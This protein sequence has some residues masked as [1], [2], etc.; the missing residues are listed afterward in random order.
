[1]RC[2][3]RDDAKYAQYIAHRDAYFS[4][5]LLHNDINLVSISL[6]V[7]EPNDQNAIPLWNA[8]G[9]PI[10]QAMLRE[11]GFAKHMNNR[12]TQ[13]ISVQRLSVRICGPLR[14]FSD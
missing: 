9:P 10:R 14:R 6:K 7:D 8:D 4:H 13:L 5:N 1:M 2:A 12:G 11:W 3:M